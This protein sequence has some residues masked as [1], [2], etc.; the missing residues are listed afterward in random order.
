MEYIKVI[1]ENIE[2]EHICCVISNNND[3]QIFERFCHIFIF[4]IY[5]YAARSRLIYFQ[6][7]YNVEKTF[8]Y[9][10]KNNDGRN[11]DKVCRKI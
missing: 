6:Y 10:H 8:T 4:A 9:Y 5:P 7:K 11:S 3:V 1:S 2:K